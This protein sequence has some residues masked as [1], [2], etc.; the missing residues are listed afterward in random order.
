ME[1]VLRDG[2][3]MLKEQAP[4]GL[5]PNVQ[6][7]GYDDRQL[8]G[9][10]RKA[11]GVNAI[12]SAVRRSAERT[13]SCG[14]CGA[15]G[16]AKSPDT[17]D[18]KLRCAVDWLIRRHSTLADGSD[19][20]DES[21][22]QTPLLLVPR[23]RLDLADR[24]LVL[25]AAPFAC[26]C[27][28]VA[29]RSELLFELADAANATGGSGT[30]AATAIAEVAEG[31]AS[32]RGAAG[33]TQQARLTLQDAASL[34]HT[35]ELMAG[36]LPPLSIC[37]DMNGE[38]VQVK[39]RTGP[40]QIAQML[41][42]VGEPVSTQKS[43]KKQKKRRKSDSVANEPPASPQLKPQSSKKKRITIEKVLNSSHKQ[44][45][46]RKKS[47]ETQA[48]VEVG[49]STRSAPGKLLGTLSS[50]KTKKVKKRSSKRE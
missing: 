45:K 24:A 15:A 26:P 18:G 11:D 43:K 10:S 6:P 32:Q 4:C 8:L 34:A 20:D 7:R 25:D 33:N 39:E 22:Q 49:R 36:G 48:V 21:V 38:V 50:E 30:P 41:L 1:R 46:K 47:L 29:M 2:L 17:D 14:V 27:C 3:S 13:R 5:R 19:G 40:N 12:A 23:W 31:Y 37:L 42:G 28:A 44:A 16:R 35:L 9:L